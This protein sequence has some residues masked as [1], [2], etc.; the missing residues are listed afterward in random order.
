MMDELE[1]PSGSGSF[2]RRWFWV[3]AVVA[4]VAIAS[5]VAL[6]LPRIIAAY[7]L[8]W[9]RNSIQRLFYEDLG[10]SESWSAFIAVV[11][12]FVY[13][14]AWVPLS[15]WTSRLLAWRFNSR[16]L[17]VAFASWVF[18]YGH[19]PLLHALLGS[20]SC[21]NQRTG[22][23]LKWYAEN[24]NGDI[25]LYD[26]G[27]F[28]TVTREEKRPVTPE[29]CASFARQ[30]ANGRPRKIT[31][32]LDDIEFF[33]PNSGR[34]RV[35]YSQ[36]AD[37][38]YEL[39]DSRGFNPATAEKLLPVTKEVIAN[40]LARA[41]T[42]A[43]KA[44]DARK[45]A[46]E[47]AAKKTT[48]NVKRITAN[49]VEIQF[50]D[51]VDG[52]PRVWYSKAANG[53]YELFDSSGFNPSTSE[54][55]LPV[56]REIV[57]DILA[58][59]AKE[60]AEADA[61]NAAEADTAKRVARA[62]SLTKRDQDTSP[63]ELSGLWSVSYPEG[64]LRVRVEQRGSQVVGILLDGNHFVPSGN[65]VITATIN[66][67]SNEFHAKQTCGSW[68]GK[69]LFSV[70]VKFTI[71]DRDNMIEETFQGSCGPPTTIAWHKLQ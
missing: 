58:R 8:Y 5:I 29:I 4:A 27:G 33:D 51:S 50:F 14:L 40:I 16:Q 39:F 63:V 7:E 68:G 22:G 69:Q 46:A 38:T 15:L 56:T 31:V 17:V 9:S 1:P 2:G 11:G 62:S 42:E 64:P 57:A 24:A 3:L 13:A 52:R 32:N 53:S 67:S 10:L 43:R 70:D 45:R 61:R 59:A 28:D 35:W 23:P 48:S 66:P 30:K 71:F 55:L 36:A 47:A 37:D 12:S 18:I 65:A 19:V 6:R 20:D 49:I 60:A 44:E 34:A 21:F 25:T 41:A 26:S 54:A